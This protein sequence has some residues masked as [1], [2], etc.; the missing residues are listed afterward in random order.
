MIGKEGS[1][2]VFRMNS[3]ISP[4]TRDYLFDSYGRGLIG[5]GYSVQGSSEF[6]SGVLSTIKATNVGSN[7]KIITITDGREKITK[8]MKLI[9][10][11]TVRRFRLK[12]FACSGF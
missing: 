6:F 7:A 3:D 4:P 5:G 10:K 8:T 11:Q 2:S 12:K 9:D 1:I